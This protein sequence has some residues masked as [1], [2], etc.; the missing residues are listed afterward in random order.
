MTPEDK[1]RYY[2]ERYE[3]LKQDPEWVERTR[4]SNREYKR[5]VM[6][7]PKA[8]AAMNAKRR[9]WYERKRKEARA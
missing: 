5:S 8:R 6:A 7:N 9:A 3:M 1:R 2:H 4:E